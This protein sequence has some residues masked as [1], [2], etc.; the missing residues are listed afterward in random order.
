MLFFKNLRKKKAEV[1]MLDPDVEESPVLRNEMDDWND[2]EDNDE[3]L[4]DWD[5]WGDDDDD[6]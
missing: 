5:D 3:V 4:D 2:E 1:L 6:D